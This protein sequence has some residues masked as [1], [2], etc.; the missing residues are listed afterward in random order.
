LANHH[1]INFRSDLEFSILLMPLNDRLRSEMLN[2]M[3]S[4]RKTCC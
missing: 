3:P 4:L 1:L 2:F